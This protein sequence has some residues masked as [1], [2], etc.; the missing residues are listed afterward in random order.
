LGSSRFCRSIAPLAI[1]IWH[2]KNPHNDVMQK[3]KIVSWLGLHPLIRAGGRRGHRLP[4]DIESM[5]AY[6][7]KNMKRYSD[8]DTP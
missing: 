7:Q 5:P 3:P 2:L 8:G 1:I 4:P 6:V